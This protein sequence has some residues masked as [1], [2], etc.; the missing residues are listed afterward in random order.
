M[1]GW[2]RD[3][4]VEVSVGAIRIRVRP[5]DLGISNDQLASERDRAVHEK[6]ADD[7]AAYGKSTAELQA[8]AEA[9]GYFG[10]PAHDAWAAAAAARVG[11]LLFADWWQRF[12]PFGGTA[13]NGPDVLPQGEY[14]GVLSRIA[15]AHDTDWSLGRYFG[16]G[17]MRALRG[18]TLPPA[19]LGAVGLVGAANISVG[20]NPLVLYTDGHGDWDVHYG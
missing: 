8:M 19:V 17:P 12:D 9:S 11:G 4:K 7:L 20:M 5:L 10:G 13:G 3:D 2:G 18:S 14:P 1:F 15:M 6:N 16:V